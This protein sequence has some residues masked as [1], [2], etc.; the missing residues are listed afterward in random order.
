MSNLTKL[1]DIVKNPSGLDSLANYMGEVPEDKWLCVLTRSRDSDCL[2]ESNWRIALKMLGGESDSVR[3][4]RFGH[5]ACGWWESLSVLSGSAAHKIGEEIKEKIDR[6]PV[7]DEEDWSNL[8]ADE[9]SELWES[10]ST[11]DR[12]DWMRTNYGSMYFHSLSDLIG[13]ARG[14]Y[15]CGNAGELLG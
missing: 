2:T 3:I 11:K 1:K 8:E 7:L 12:I 4:D 9:A 5:W 15:F 13:C 10:F 14:K 6:Y